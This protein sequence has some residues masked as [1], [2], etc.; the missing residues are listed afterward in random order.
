MVGAGLALRF[1]AIDT[2]QGGETTPIHTDVKILTDD[3]HPL[4]QYKVA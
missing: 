1:K 3:A 4:P 2:N